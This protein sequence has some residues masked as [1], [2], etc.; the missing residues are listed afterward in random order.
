M[1]GKYA[2][3]VGI[4]RVVMRGRIGKGEREVRFIGR[5]SERSDERQMSMSRERRNEHGERIW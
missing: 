3:W 4:V 2:L 1:R 5:C